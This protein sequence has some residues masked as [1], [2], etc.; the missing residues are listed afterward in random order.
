MP[1]AD[2]TLTIVKVGGS[3]FCRSDLAMRLQ[4]FLEQV[5]E[6]ALL[7]PGGGELVDVLRRWHRRH[8]WNEATAHWAAV[9]ALDVNAWLLHRM[10]PGSRLLP[11]PQEFPSWYRQAALRPA[12]K[13]QSVCAPWPWLSSG[14]WGRPLPE[15]PATWDVTSDAIAAWIA[16][17]LGARKL[18]LLKSAPPP[19]TLQQATERGYVDP[20]LARVVSQLP[21][22]TLQAVCLA[23]ESAQQAVW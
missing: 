16:G 4:A 7:V 17:K 19:P 2:Q 18:V 10:L 8:G 13:N 5:A 3:L 21:C 12:Q 23:G 15:L 22:L 14:D 11:V 6:P 20:W 1:P 9:R